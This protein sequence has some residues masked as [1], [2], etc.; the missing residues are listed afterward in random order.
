MYIYNQAL[1]GCTG[2]ASGPCLRAAHDSAMAGS[3]ATRL[4]VQCL[5][6]THRPAAHATRRGRPLGACQ[7]DAQ[8]GRRLAAAGVAETWIRCPRLRS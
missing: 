8:A 4:R 2:R 3:R 1:A 6:G 7:C 5:G